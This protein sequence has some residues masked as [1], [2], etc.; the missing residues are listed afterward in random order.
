[1]TIENAYGAFQDDMLGSLK[2]DKWADFIVIDVNPLTIAPDDLKDNEIEQVL[3]QV[4][5]Y[6][7]PRNSPA[8]SCVH[9]MLSV[10]FACPLGTLL[11]IARN[12]HRLSR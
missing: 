3:L 7:K 4:N 2:T 9:A 8:F 6:I 1:M 11:P 5:A 12:Q 10:L